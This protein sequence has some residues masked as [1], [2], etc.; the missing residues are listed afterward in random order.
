MKI[1]QVQFRG[2]ACVRLEAA[3]ARVLVALQ[4]AQVLS[5]QTPDGCERLFL[6]ERARLDGGAA[7]RGGVPVI[8]PQ[9]GARGPLAKHG[10]ARLRRWRLVGEVDG[11][12]GF[13]LTCDGTDAGWPHACA[14]RLR[15]RPEA[16][17]LR[18]DLEVVNTGASALAFSA[19][20]HGYLRV[21]ALASAQL[22]GLTGQRYEDSAGG[23]VARLDAAPTL[24]FDGEVDRIYVAPAQALELREGARGLRLSQ[25]GFGEVVVWNPGATLAAGIDD[26][27]PD[28]YA[29]FVCV[30]AAQVFEPVALAAGARWCGWQAI[31]AMP[32]SG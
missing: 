23:G 2:A 6:G 14:V 27:A 11:A 28:E 29:R 30:E 5:W 19:A 7:I 17:R 18:L 20:L 32:A 22:H 8:F 4:G 21:D 9:F 12:A 25:A 31:E 10:F 16:T 3:G 13:E 15:V 24:R 1:E 26:L